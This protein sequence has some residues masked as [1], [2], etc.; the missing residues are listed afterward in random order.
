MMSVSRLVD[1]HESFDRA[2]KLRSALFPYLWWI[3]NHFDNE[4]L[5]VLFFRFFSSFARESV[6]FLKFPDFFFFTNQQANEREELKLCAVQLN[7][8]S[9]YYLFLIT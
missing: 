5:F 1:E 2:V 8:H 3:C 6:V 7:L 4:F 9:I